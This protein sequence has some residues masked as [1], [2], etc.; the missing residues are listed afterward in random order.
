MTDKEIMPFTF[1]L[2]AE[3]LKESA[4]LT[5]KEK[6][7]WLEE[8]NEFIEK[9]VDPGILKR[10]QELRNRAYFWQRGHQ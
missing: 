2:S 10:W 7:E 5:A 1:T 4:H 6:L 9:C 8:A 3:K